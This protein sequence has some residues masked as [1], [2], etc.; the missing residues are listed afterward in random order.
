VARA[1]DHAVG[2]V[3]ARFRP[4]HIFARC[5]AALDFWLLFSSRIARAPGLWITLHRLLLIPLLVGVARQRLEFEHG[6]ALNRVRCR[7]RSDQA[8]ELLAG[9]SGVAGTP[10]ASGTVDDLEVVQVH[11]WAA[12]WRRRRGWLIVPAFVRYRARV[13]SMPPRRR[14]KSLRGNLARARR[15]GFHSRPG[16][17]G[18]WDRARAMAEAWG[19]A[20]F[21]SD[22]WMPPEHAW[23]R[24]RR[25][26]RLI[27]IGD[28]ARDVASAI[29]VA[30]NGGDEAWFASIGLTGGDRNLLRAGALTAAYAAAVTEAR[31]NGASTFDTGRCSARADD[32]IAAYKMRWGLRPTVD[33]LSPVY[34]LR[35]RTPAG[36]RILATLPLWALGAGAALRRV[37]PS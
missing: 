32:P 17:G 8:A 36:K 14:S 15:S 37:G 22:V 35:A 21:G 26:A 2:R 30:A 6:S 19:R 4:R 12:A 3:Q 5:V 23:K 7:V 1:G 16:G 31:R 10:A 28:G 34:A 18:D 9:P 33:A 25:H 24:I 20:R 27:M 13:D 11:P 29:L